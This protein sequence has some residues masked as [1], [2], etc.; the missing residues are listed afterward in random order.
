[1]LPDAYVFSP[2][3]FLLI[4][5]TLVGVVL[6]LFL[7][8]KSKV[9]SAAFLAI[10]TLASSVWAFTYA[11]EYAA[12]DVASKIFWSKLSY[13][14]IAFCPVTFFFFTL[15]FS[16]QT[17][18]LKKKYI[19]AA[20]SLA[21]LYILS[22]ATN[23][24]HHL[25]WISVDIY[26]ETNTTEYV[27]GPLFWLFY[28]VTYSFLV[29]G[30]VN[31]YLLFFRFPSRYKSQIG[32]FILATLFPIAGNVMYV[33]NLNPVPGFDWTPLSFV[34]SGFLL[35]VNIFRFHV[36]SLIPFARNKLFDMMPD[37]VLVI[38]RDGKVADLNPSL[39][40]FSGLNEK[41][42]IGR[43]W[44][45]L[46]QNWSLPVSLDDREQI[47]HFD[48]EAN[49]RG[50][51]IYYSV[52]CIPL[53]D[54][55]RNFSGNLINFRDVTVQK[56]AELELQTMNEKLKQEIAEKETLIVDLDAFAHTV[57]HDLKNMLGAII[58]SG[59]LLTNSIETGNKEETEEILDLIKFSS[60]KTL[61]VTQELLLLASVRQ[62]EI[63][64]DML[65]M[66]EIVEE[67]IRRNYSEIHESKA[68]IIKPEGC[69]PS[70]G[71]APWV[72]EV[73]AN[74]ISNAI[75]YGGDPPIVEF[76]S[77]RIDGDMIK[78]WIK[79]NG[80]G[81]PVEQQELLFHKF[82]RL[83]NIKVE[84]HGLGLSIVRRIIEKLGGSV[85]VESTAVPD[86]GA[87]FYFTLPAN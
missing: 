26:P 66:N 42:I 60:R 40:L 62:Q 27:Y 85:G 6:S 5:T 53:L 3:Y 87:I 22:S 69:I 24:L 61:H 68:V 82:T 4:I 41:D 38:D 7:F 32:I 2:L 8:G 54:D 16:S 44:N 47:R 74:Y 55:N 20:Y 78:Y 77:E 73:W 79:D 29:A 80:W 21:V 48:V 70:R 36:F 65:D 76:G 23:D 75:K 13:L 15:A 71:Y 45:D 86:E 18:F 50:S 35:S 11:F 57:A 9:P 83:V 43:Q 30:I 49:H 52:Q 64:T 58:M 14:G 84:G 25:H 10:W 1:M 33:F 59:D 56:K 46:F 37:A 19:I 81:I 72:E 28:F 39:Q 34:V 51:I 31:L 17:R 67:A 63:V 12:T